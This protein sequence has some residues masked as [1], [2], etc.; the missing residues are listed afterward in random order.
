MLDINFIKS[1]K[2]RVEEAIRNK[3]IKTKIDVNELLEI[4]SK[5]KNNLKQIEKLRAERN[6]IAELIP[7]SDESNKIELIKEGTKL[8][9]EVQKLELE[10]TQLEAKFTS[11]IEMIPNI[12]STK[13]P[14]G[15]SDEENVVIRKWGEPRQF[16]FNPKD[17]VDLGKSL[18]IIDVEKSAEISGPRF[19][20]LKGD[21]VLIQFGIINLVF[22]T[23]SNQKILESIAKKAGVKSTKPFTPVLPPVMM[24]PSVMK[25]MDRLDPID[26][27][28]LMKNDDLILVGSAEHTLGPLHM[29][30]VFDHDQL[31]VRYIGYSTA[32]RREAGSYGKDTKGILRVHQFDKLEMETYTTEDQGENEQEFIVAIQEYLV[33]QLNLPYQVVQI[34]TGDTGKPD[35]NQYDIETWIP[36]QN[37][38]RETHTS[39]YMTDYQSRRLNIKYKDMKGNKKFVHMNDA[40]AFAI[41]RILIAILE[42]YQQSDGTILVPEV[43]RDYVGKKFIGRK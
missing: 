40:T 33:Q 29:N 20:Y 1:N 28:Y 41:S 2:T 8:K 38:Y 6:K 25:K 32:F 22:K 14:V 11:L 7:T 31:P 12:T 23:L 26:E 24:K 43:L 4:D 35:Y 39:D 5:I 13:M 16:D 3:K 27:R 17:H 21:A 34:C 36:T 30:E 37:K 19:Y 9:E 42:N 18:N 10:Q 15:E